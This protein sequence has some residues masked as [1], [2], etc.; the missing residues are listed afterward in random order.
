MTT[1][2]VQSITLV[3]PVSIMRSL[4]ATEPGYV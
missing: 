4:D 2:L 1:S 3:K